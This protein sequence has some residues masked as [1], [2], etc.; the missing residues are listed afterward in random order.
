M[1]HPDSETSFRKYS[2]ICQCSRLS[3]KE[4]LRMQ[5]HLISFR[6]QKLYCQ[7]SHNDRLQQGGRLKLPGHQGPKAAGCSCSQTWAR[8]QLLLSLTIRWSWLFLMLKEW[9]VSLLEKT[10]LDEEVQWTTAQ[11]LWLSCDGGDNC[12]APVTQLLM[13][14]YLWQDWS[15]IMDF[16]MEIELWGNSF[17]L[18]Y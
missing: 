7:L 15:F 14:L 18:C 13:V 2:I 5:L 1:N 17:L 8:W 3:G 4:K 12:C 9:K 6:R 10:D 16:P 11:N